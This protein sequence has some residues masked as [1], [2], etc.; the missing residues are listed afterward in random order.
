[1]AIVCR[2]CVTCILSDI[3]WMLP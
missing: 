2:N 3:H 1:M